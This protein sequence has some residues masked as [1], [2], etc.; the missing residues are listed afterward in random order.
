[1]FALLGSRRFAPLFFTQFFSA[2]SDNFLKTALVFVILATI[3]G[4]AGESLVTAAGGLFIAPFFLLS[5]LGGEWA[6]RYD[7]AML[8]RRLKLAELGAALVAVAGF[9]LHSLPLLFAALL[10]FG[11]IAALFGPVK[12]GILPDHLAAEELPAG[13]ALVEGATFVA[14]VLGAMLAGYAADG[15][16]TRPLRSP[17]RRAVAALLGLQPDDPVLPRGRARPEDRV[18]RPRLHLGPAPPASRR[19][20]AL[21]AR[22]LR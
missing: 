11:I 7:K 8:I 22:P 19:T 17:R 16:G 12:Y 15:E 10:M 21:A 2:F 9:T 5:A 1:M 14:I 20:P 18:E 4:S 6:D 13:N 3:G